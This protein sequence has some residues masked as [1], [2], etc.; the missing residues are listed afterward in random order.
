MKLKDI[1]DCGVQTELMDSTVHRG[2]TELLALGDYTLFELLCSREGVPLA[3]LN[4][5]AVVGRQGNFLCELCIEHLDTSIVEK[6]GIVECL[7][8]GIHGVLTAECG[9]S[10]GVCVYIG[11]GSVNESTG[12]SKK[13]KIKIE[14]LCN[15]FRWEDSY[16]ILLIR[17]GI[18]SSLVF[19]RVAFAP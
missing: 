6:L 18:A 8:G 7:D 16:L 2:H 12:I 9:S 1:G 4:T 11:A 19:Q 13:L 17:L 15:S 5:L 14:H 10:T 3:E